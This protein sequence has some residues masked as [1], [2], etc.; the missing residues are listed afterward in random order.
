[1]KNSSL[2][3]L[4]TSVSPLIYP[5]FDHLKLGHKG[6]SEI[7]RK[8]SEKLKMSPEMLLKIPEKNHKSLD[9]LVF[10]N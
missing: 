5:Y 7:S 9:S 3:P 10:T 6:L 8:I 1:L 2:P 4:P